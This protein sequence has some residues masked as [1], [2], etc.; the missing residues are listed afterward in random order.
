MDTR[1]TPAIRSCFGLFD[2]GGELE[3]AGLVMIDAASRENWRNHPQQ[4]QKRGHP[5]EPS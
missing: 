1:G 3:V 5:R 4:S 2:D